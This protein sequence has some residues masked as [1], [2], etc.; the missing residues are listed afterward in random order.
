MIIM[1]SMQ[2]CKNFNNNLPSPSPKMNCLIPM[3]QFQSRGYNRYYQLKYRRRVSRTSLTLNARCCCC[4]KMN[5]I[6]MQSNSVDM[7]KISLFVLLP[8]KIWEL[9]HLES[10]LS[11]V[12]QEVLTSQET[13][14]IF[15]LHGEEACNGD[16]SIVGT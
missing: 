10:A 8:T 4:C 15:D 11:E 7:I 2:Q 3:V 9:R 16:T 14:G 6:R 13:N 1:P 5:G 12:Q